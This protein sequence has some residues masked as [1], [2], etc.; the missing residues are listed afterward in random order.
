MEAQEAGKHNTEEQ[1]HKKLKENPIEIQV[2]EL[3]DCMDVHC[4]WRAIELLL[5]NR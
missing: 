2:G 5:P 4:H 3:V 1:S